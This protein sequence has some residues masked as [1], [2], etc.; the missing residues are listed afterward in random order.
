MAG[1]YTIAEIEEAF[2]AQFSLSGL[3]ARTYDDERIQIRWED[4][5]L[6]L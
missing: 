1:I 4:F 6:H 3:E 5:K 2:R